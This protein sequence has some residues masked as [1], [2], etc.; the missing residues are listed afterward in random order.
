MR[1]FWRL[2]NK[3]VCE[4]VTLSVHDKLRW[5]LVLKEKCVKSWVRK[6]PLGKHL[7]EYLNTERKR[8]FSSYLEGLSCSL[9]TRRPLSMSMALAEPRSTALTGGHASLSGKVN[10]FDQSLNLHVGGGEVGDGERGKDGEVRAH[11]SPVGLDWLHQSRWCTRWISCSV[12]IACW[13]DALGLVAVHA[14]CT[15]QPMGGY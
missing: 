4:S 11:I 2:Q 6:K 13:T 14:L 12:L 7:C 3:N 10:V 9:I 5:I 1:P 15:S 8:A